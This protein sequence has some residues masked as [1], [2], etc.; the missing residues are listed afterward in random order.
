MKF[1]AFS[2]TKSNNKDYQYYKNKNEEF[3][4]YL[5]QAWPIL[6]D[7]GEV[8]FKNIKESINS[9]CLEFELNCVCGTRW[10]LYGEKEEVEKI[11]KNFEK[12]L[13]N[14]K[15]TL[16]A[17]AEMNNKEKGDHLN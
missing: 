4:N 15:N 16:M 9:F 12:I 13:I 17:T 8:F 5:K 14:I 10:A 1:H 6:K 11:I 3:R 2:N 7:D